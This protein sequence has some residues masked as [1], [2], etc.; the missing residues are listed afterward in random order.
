V[1]E[2]RQTAQIRGRGRPW[3][4]EFAQHLRTCQHIQV[5]PLEPERTVRVQGIERMT[6]DR[7]VE[8]QWIRIVHEK[9]EVR[10][11]VAH[12]RGEGV[13]FGE[14][15]VRRVAHDQIGR[16]EPDPLL[17]HIK[18]FPF[19]IQ[20]V[21]RRIGTG[22]RQGTVA[23]IDTDDQRRR[24]ALL[25]CQ[26]DAPTARTDVDDASRWHPARADDEVHQFFRLRSWNEDRRPDFQV[27]PMK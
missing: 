2:T 7:P 14:R 15:N 10:F 17:Q 18:L 9:R 12:I 11:M 27:E 24:E 20:S 25:Q 23:H 3:E 19:N 1:D 13:Q 26:C 8:A 4:A 16:G 5:M 22:H 6:R 21:A